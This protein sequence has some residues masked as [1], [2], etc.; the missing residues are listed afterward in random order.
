MGIGMT[1]PRWSMLVKRLRFAFYAKSMVSSYN[2]LMIIYQDM[3]VLNAIV[4]LWLGG[5]L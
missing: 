5:I 2:P 4:K 1:I 3:D